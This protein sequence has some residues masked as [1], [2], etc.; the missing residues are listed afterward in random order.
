[1]YILSPKHAPEN[2][3]VKL[4]SAHALGL[5]HMGIVTQIPEHLDPC[6]DSGPGRV[7]LIY[8]ASI[9]CSIYVHHGICEYPLLREPEFA[10]LPSG[11]SFFF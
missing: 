10:C 3:Q 5:S 6:F 8:L 9:A 11:R 4:M 1:M 7:P 2:E